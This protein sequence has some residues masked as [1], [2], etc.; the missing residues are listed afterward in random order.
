LILQRSVEDAVQPLLAG[1]ASALA[2]TYA[3]L[4]KRRAGARTTMP[5]APASTGRTSETSSVDVI[6]FRS[7]EK[8]AKPLTVEAAKLLA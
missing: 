8:L 6:T 4:A 3:A 1:F 5:T 7:V 2:G